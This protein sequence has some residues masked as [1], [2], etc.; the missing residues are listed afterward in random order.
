MKQKPGRTGRSST[1]IHL[2]LASILLLLFLAACQSQTF[3]LPR[4]ETT[5]AVA[6]TAPQ[7]TAE[8][9]Y[10][11]A[12]TATVDPAQRGQAGESEFR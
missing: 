8:P 4:L 7:E 10:L 12:P 9:L 2:L 11:P 5:T 1:L 6:E 3:T